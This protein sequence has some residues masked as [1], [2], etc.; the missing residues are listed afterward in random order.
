MGRGRRCACM[1]GRLRVVRGR[2]RWLPGVDAEEEGGERG[3]RKKRKGL[4]TGPAIKMEGRGGSGR[5]G[6]VPGGG[7]R[8]GVRVAGNG[9]AQRRCARAGDE[10][11]TQS[12]GPRLEERGACGPCLENVGRPGKGKWA[13]P[14][15]IWN[16]LIYS[17]E[18]QKEVN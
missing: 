18:F 1:S 17:K 14:N 10:W 5:G 11:G 12:G 6:R 8:G 15:I 4:G 13:G 9:R 16:F 2:Q 7:A 3:G